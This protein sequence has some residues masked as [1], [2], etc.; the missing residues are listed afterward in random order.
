MFSPHL[1]HGRNWF[2]TP[3][4][5]TRF[6]PDELLNPYSG[7]WTGNVVVASHFLHTPSTWGTPGSGVPSAQ[8]WGGSLHSGTDAS[9][10]SSAVAGNYSPSESFGTRLKSTSCCRITRIFITFSTPPI[11]MVSSIS[12]P[13]KWEKITRSPRW[14]VIGT[15]L[16]ENSA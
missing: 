14:T 2:L 11:S 7:M 6:L 8:R 16:P 10:G 5:P 4:N 12:L 13:A 1:L 9:V 3:C 15:T